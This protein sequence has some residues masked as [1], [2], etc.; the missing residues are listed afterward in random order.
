ML[1]IFEEMSVRETASAMGC[2]EGTVKALLHKATK[3][4]KT[5]MRMTD[6]E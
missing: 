4:L 1:R 5:N 3:S 2:R 6:Y